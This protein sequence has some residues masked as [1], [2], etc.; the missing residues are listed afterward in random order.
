MKILIYILY[1][2]ITCKF[3]YY[4]NKSNILYKLILNFINKG[5][6]LST[7]ASFVNMYFFSKHKLNIEYE[8]KEFWNQFLNENNILTP[9]IYIKNDI[10]KNKQYII[11]PNIGI[12]GNDIEI[13]KFK[14]IN[15]IDEFLVQ[16]LLKDEYVN[17]AR[18]FRIIT[19]Y[20]GTCLLIFEMINKYKITSNIH[21]GG[22]CKYLCLNNSFLSKEETIKI[23][24]ITNKL[25]KIHKY[26][27]DNIFSIGWDVM[28]NKKQLYVL[29]G[30]VR[31]PGI[32]LTTQNNYD[33]TKY[34]HKYIK[35]AMIFDNKYKVC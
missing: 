25:C 22:I 35:K 17:Y 28:F 20:D 15:F 13:K 27:L 24:I 34:F 31:V 14:D 21:S 12:H 23:K 16:D 2:F 7:E 29:E 1:D 26:K 5:F 6:I 9:N 18:S 33:Y 3:S 10:L 4:R 30:N 8:T 11:K 19:I 32:I